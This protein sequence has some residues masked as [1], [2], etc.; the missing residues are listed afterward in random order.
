MSHKLLYSSIGLLSVGV[1]GLL[2]AIAL[3][4]QTGEAVYFLLMKVAAGL[5]GIGGPLFGWAVTRR[6]KR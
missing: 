3:E 6:R 1:I 5:F 2:I 4:I